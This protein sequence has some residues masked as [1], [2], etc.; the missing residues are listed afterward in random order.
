MSAVN[1]RPEQLAIEVG[2]GRGAVRLEALPQGRD[3]LLRITGGEDHVGAVAV[4][5]EGDV[6]LH[7]IGPHK[8]GPLAEDAA[9]R[10]AAMTGTV[11]VSAVGIHQDDITREEIATIVA[12]VGAGL[13]A[14]QKIWKDRRG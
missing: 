13:T 3:W 6:H 7:V 11:C 12:N 14:L 2:A 1:H 9:R 8:E 5:A 4:A 10:W